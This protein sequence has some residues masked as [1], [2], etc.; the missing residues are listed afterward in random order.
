M[1]QDQYKLTGREEFIMDLLKAPYGVEMTSSDLVRTAGGELRS[2]GLMAVLEGL[3]QRGYLKSR[4]VKPEGYLVDRRLFSIDHIRLHKESRL[5]LRTRLEIE[6]I[7][8]FKIAA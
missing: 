7:C 5:R 8:N 4:F 6:R 3:E 2:E 1:K